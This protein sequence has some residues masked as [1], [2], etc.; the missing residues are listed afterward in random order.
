MQQ[1][2]SLPPA[3]ALLSSERPRNL[4]WFGTV[5]LLFGA[6][7]LGADKVLIGSSRR[8][9]LH[10]LIKRNFQ[11]KLESLLPPEIPVAVVGRREAVEAHVST[12]DEPAHNRA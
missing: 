1:A 10:H 5:G 4:S 11:K 8:G 7:L 9:A 3:L 2:K 6:A 12:G